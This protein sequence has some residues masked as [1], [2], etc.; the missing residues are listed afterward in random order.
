MGYGDGTIV[1]EPSGR[2][3]GAR[4]I[5]GKRV[6][7]R[8]NTKTEVREKL[9]AREQAAAAGLKANPRMTV[10]EVLEAWLA[11][12]SP[13]R[14]RVNS[15]NTIQSHRWAVE[16]H[17]VPNLGKVLL[18]E[19]T[20]EDVE[21]VFKDLAR[22]GR[23]TTSAIGLG[24][25]TLVKLRATLHM[26]LDWASR[27]QWIRWNAAVGVEIPKTATAPTR[28]KSLSVD[29]V[30]RLLI[31]ARDDEMYGAIWLTMLAVGLRPGE[32]T[33]L[34]RND[35]DLERGLLAVVHSLAREPDDD[36]H[37]VLRLGPVKAGS[38]RTVALPPSAV[39]AIRR[40]LG[41][42]DARKVLAGQGWEDPGWEPLFAT[43]WGGPIDPSNLRR[44]FRQVI[45]AAAI[46]GSWAPYELRHTN[47]SLL[48]EVGVD[49]RRIADMAGHRNTRMIDSTYRHALNPVQDASLEMERFL[50]GSQSAPSHP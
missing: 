19:L 31:A 18:T 33:G 47:I 9:R 32:A 43:T 13:K 30:E 23:S 41:A 44:A 37:Q 17:L 22:G 12:A 11:E 8:G 48:S 36:G 29:E 15:A 45:E 50:T 24:R 46:E 21:A 2:Y 35:V 16:K 3:R 4:I 27:K 7:V 25:D 40:H 20:R 5:K 39:A 14:A 42:Q 49:R 6:Y 10:G 34:G 38:E 26:A 1:Q 28:R